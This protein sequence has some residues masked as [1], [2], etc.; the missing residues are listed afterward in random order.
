MMPLMMRR[1]FCC[2]GPVWTI[3]S[4]GAINA[5]CPSESQ[6]LSAEIRILPESLNHGGKLNSIGYGP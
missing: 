3:G 2:A 6:K 4:S 1:S 5:H